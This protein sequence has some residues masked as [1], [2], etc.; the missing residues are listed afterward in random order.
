MAS[1]TVVV[2]QCR[3]GWLCH[4]RLCALLVRA[5]AAHV[6]AGAFFAVLLDTVP[7]Q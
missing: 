6:T 3:I 4:A 1:S 2:T 7:V 5:Q